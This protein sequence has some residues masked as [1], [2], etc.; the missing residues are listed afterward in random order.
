MPVGLDDWLRL[1]EEYPD[2]YRHF[3]WSARENVSHQIGLF[4]CH[5]EAEA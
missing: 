1:S 3:H 2:V 5:D 4:E